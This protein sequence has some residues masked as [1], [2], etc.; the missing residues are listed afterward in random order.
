MI[1]V[2]SSIKQ[3]FSGGKLVNS[4]A[5][6]VLGDLLMETSRSLRE[7]FCILGFEAVARRAGVFADPKAQVVTLRRR[8]GLTVPEYL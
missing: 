3:S 2:A 8:S 7:L 5:D 4:C 1:A 6:C